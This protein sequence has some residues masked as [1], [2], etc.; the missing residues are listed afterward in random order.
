[1]NSATLLIPREEFVAMTYVYS[2]A[3]LIM[4]KS[5]IER[6]GNLAKVAA[7]VACP[8]GITISV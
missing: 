4:V 6:Y 7:A 5:S 2:D 8:D 3:M 1:M